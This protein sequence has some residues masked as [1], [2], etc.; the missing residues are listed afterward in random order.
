MQ[1]AAAHACTCKRRAARRFV[2]PAHALKPPL[3]ICALPAPLR[4]AA[5][6]NEGEAGVAG[7]TY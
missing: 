3:K 2:H 7:A 6:K 4:E 5:K 1:A